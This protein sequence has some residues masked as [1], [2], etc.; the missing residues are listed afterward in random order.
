M[1]CITHES[2]LYFIL[3]VIL[4]ILFFFQ[5]YDKLFN[6]KVGGVI[7]FFRQESS[8]KQIPGFVLV[9]S[10]YFTSIVEFVCGGLLIL[11]FFKTWALYLLGIDLIL[12]CGAF[13]ILKPMWDMQLLFPRLILL[14]AL[15]YLPQQWDQLSLDYLLRY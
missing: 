11:G 13:S 6:L 8:H 4:G 14:A 9:G 3:R 5:G 15:L 12:V 2:V 1:S 7:A 10:A